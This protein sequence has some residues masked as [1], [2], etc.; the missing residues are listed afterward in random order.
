MGMLL[1]RYVAT[2]LYGNDVNHTN[3]IFEVELGFLQSIFKDSIAKSVDAKL[4]E[5]LEEE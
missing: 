1:F 3:I 4:K 5:I 2:T